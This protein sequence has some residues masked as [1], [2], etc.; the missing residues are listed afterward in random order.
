MFYFINIHFFLSIGRMQGHHRSNH[1]CR[2]CHTTHT[3]NYMTNPHSNCS[4]MVCNISTAQ[5]EQSVEG[6]DLWFFVCLFLFYPYLRSHKILTICR[7]YYEG[8]NFFLIILR[9]LVVGQLELETRE[10]HTA[11]L[12]TLT[13]NSVD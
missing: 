11:V 12:S 6:W 3:V 13:C 8:S 7:H 5:F 1:Q 4:I 2:T 10:F 9:P